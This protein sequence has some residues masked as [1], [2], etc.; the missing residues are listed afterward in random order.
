MPWGWVDISLSILRLVPRL[1]ICRMS[2]ARRGGFMHA[3]SRIEYTVAGQ[4]AQIFAVF[5]VPRGRERFSLSATSSPYFSILLFALHRQPAWA[6]QETLRA[7][8]R[9]QQ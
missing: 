7:P 2:R 4:L 8:R 3:I 6:P 1:S 5:F 9:K